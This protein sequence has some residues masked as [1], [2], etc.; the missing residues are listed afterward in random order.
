MARRP[1]AATREEGEVKEEAQNRRSPLRPLVVVLLLYTLFFLALFS[2]FAARGRLPGNID[3]WYAIAFTNSYLNDLRDIFGGGDSGSFLYP[4]SEPLAY[5]ETSV[6]LALIPMA[7]RGAGLSDVVAYDLFLVIIYALTAFGAFLVAGLY[8]DRRPLAALA[9]IVFAASNFMLSTIDSPHTTFFGLA[10]LSIYFF[11]RHLQSGAV[12]HLALSAAIAGIQTYLSAYV[13][14][15]LAVAIGALAVANVRTLIGSRAAA[16]R[17]LA[18]GLLTAA[19][20]GPFYVSYFL[21]LNDYFSWRSQALLFAEFNSLD[22]QDLLNP[23]PGNLIY[24]EGPRFSHSDAKRLQEYLGREDPSLKSDEFFLM[25]GRS[26]SEYEESLW[27]SSRKRAFFGIVP[28]LLAAVGAFRMRAGR[29]E[30]LLLGGVA[31]L[32][33]LGP[34][35][36]IG[37]RSVPMPAWLLYEHLPGFHMFRIP[38]R[39]FA[40]T[41]LVVAIMAARGL[42]VLLDRS[43]WIT[44][45][46]TAA[47]ALIAAAVVVIE[48]VPFPMRSFEGASVTMP[49]PDYRAWFGDRPGAVILNLPSGIGYGL[50]GSAD[51]LNVFNRELIYMNWQSYLRRSI[52]NGVNG[53]IPNARIGIQ[54]HIEKLPGDEAVRGLADIGITHIV[55]NKNLLLPGE[56]VLLRRLGRSP[57]LEP[58]LDS[59][60]TTI[61]GILP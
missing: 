17:L 23:M 44:P 22:I 5:G 7:L 14:L 11:K 25:I 8:V 29:S 40:L 19:I 49:P 46:R 38:G 60:T 24:P 50:A 9:G 4:V 39:A 41:L 37:D 13:F 54:A 26:P 51:D 1:A 32:L 56:A 61:F 30:L 12:L 6:A 31:L 10:F 21:R 43:G 15:L 34:V 53:Y 48:N 20:A 42:G 58:L 27:V 3:T 33:A 59:R 47:V 55:F 18:A 16:T 52:A 57:L 36:Q 45:R 2:Q 28:L 35:N